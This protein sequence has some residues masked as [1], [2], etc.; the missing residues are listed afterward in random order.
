MTFVQ[1]RNRLTTLFSERVPVVVTHFFI[2]PWTFYDA[3]RPRLVGSIGLQ[4]CCVSR[5]CFEKVVIFVAASNQQN[6]QAVVLTLSDK[7]RL[8]LT[9]VIVPRMSAIGRVGHSDTVSEL[10]T[11]WQTITLGKWPTWCTITLYET[12]YYCNPLHVSSNTVRIIRRSDCINTASGIVLSVSDRPVCRLISLFSNCTPDGHLQS[13]IPDA[14][15][16]FW[17][18]NYFFLF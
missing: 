5:V 8:W 15:L 18:R 6:T 10:Y 13:T 7:L 14:V 3:E 9:D 12:I 11:K 4:P 16:T 1:R 17:R 2:K